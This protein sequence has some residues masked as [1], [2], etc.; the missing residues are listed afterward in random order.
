MDCFTNH[1]CVDVCVTKIEV[2]RVKGNRSILEAWLKDQ[3]TKL[4]AGEH[5]QVGYTVPSSQVI[6]NIVAV[7]HGNGCLWELEVES[8]AKNH[9]PIIWDGDEP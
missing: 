3:R 2:G 4:F 1:D 7:Q 9:W 6:G 5:H 8:N